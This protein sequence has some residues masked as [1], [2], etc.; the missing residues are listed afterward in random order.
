MHS[1]RDVKYI[2]IPMISEANASG[3]ANDSFKRMPQESQIRREFQLRSSLPIFTKARI[4]RKRPDAVPML[5]SILIQDEIG[6]PDE[7][8]V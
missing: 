1:H 3:A 6:P 2:I 8:N 5:T 4:I 7:E